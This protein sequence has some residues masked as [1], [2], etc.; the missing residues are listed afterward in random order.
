MKATS[1][2]GLD[3][4]T[5]QPLCDG[6]DDEWGIAIRGFARAFNLTFFAGIRRVRPLSGACHGSSL[7]LPCAGAG[8]AQEGHTGVAASGRWARRSCPQKAHAPS[9]TA[10]LSSRSQ[11]DAARRAQLGTCAPDATCFGASDPASLRADI[12]D[13]PRS[14]RARGL[15]LAGKRPSTQRARLDG[16]ATANPCTC[17]VSA[18]LSGP[19]TE[20]P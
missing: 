17:W 13:A 1:R 14:G 18:L 5:I 7:T 2:G 10:L 9:V 15:P 20:R 6:K 11:R 12:H 19:P 16:L 8:V 4:I 3:E